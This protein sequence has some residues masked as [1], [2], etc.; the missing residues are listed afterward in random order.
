MIGELIQQEEEAVVKWWALRWGVAMLLSSKDGMER[1]DLG[2]NISAAGCKAAVSHQRRKMASPLHH[3]DHPWWH[4][5]GFP[6]WSDA[7]QWRKPGTIPPHQTRGGAGPGTRAG[8]YTFSNN[9]AMLLHFNPPT[10]L[11]MILANYQLD[12][13]QRFKVDVFMKWEFGYRE[14]AS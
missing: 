10:Q 3:M 1:K 5:G 13:G 14:E 9:S 4:V 7:G 11:E 8:V 6:G 2:W 12:S